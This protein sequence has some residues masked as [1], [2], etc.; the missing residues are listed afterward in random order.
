MDE[1]IKSTDTTDTRSDV[2]RRTFI[3]LSLIHI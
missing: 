2:S 1:D 3:K